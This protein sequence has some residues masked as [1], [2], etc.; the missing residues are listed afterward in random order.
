MSK[1]VSHATTPRTR[2]LQ[3][4]AIGEW[5]EDC[6]QTVERDCSINRIVGELG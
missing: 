3:R 2:T 6:V 5:Y 4:M 1:A